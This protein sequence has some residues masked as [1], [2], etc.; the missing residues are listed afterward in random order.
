[1]LPFCIVFSNLRGVFLLKHI[2]TYFEVDKQLLVKLKKIVAVLGL[3]LFFCQGHLDDA[4]MH[5]VEALAVG[6]PCNLDQ[7]D[8]LLHNQMVSSQ[9]ALGRDVH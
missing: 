2:G 7:L 4:T 9:R 1:M 3:L 5:G 6:I 8:L